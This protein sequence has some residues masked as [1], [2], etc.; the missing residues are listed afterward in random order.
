L[1]QGRVEDAERQGL[2]VL[3]HARIHGLLDLPHVGYYL[4]TLG[5][6]TARSGRL[7]QG[8][9]LLDTGIRQLAEWDPLLAGHARLMRA[10]VRRQLCGRCSTRPRPCWRCAATRNHRR[11]R[12][13]GRADSRDVAPAW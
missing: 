11:H 13:V 1:S 8:D 7:E 9:E 6:A 10:P 12:N 2:S 5:A 3:E 4:A